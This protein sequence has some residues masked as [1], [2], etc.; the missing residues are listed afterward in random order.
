MGRSLPLDPPANPALNTYTAVGGQK[1]SH[2]W[3]RA[4]LLLPSPERRDDTTVNRRTASAGSLCQRAIMYKPVS[5]IALAHAA[6][7]A[8][9]VLVAFSARPAWSSEA[10]P[11]AVTGN[12]TTRVR[13]TCKHNALPSVP[14]GNVSKNIS[15]FAKKN[16]KLTIL[17]LFSK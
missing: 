11:D 10:V 7:A 3:A 9:V 15:V 1:T 12:S 4:P 6:V 17:Q 14:F 5:G 13:G 16:K 2:A 8:A